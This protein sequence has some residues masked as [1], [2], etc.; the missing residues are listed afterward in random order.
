MLATPGASPRRE[1]GARAPTMNDLIQSLSSETGTAPDMI[2]SVLGAI[3]DFLR[4]HLD[5][6]LVDQIQSHVPG[7]ADLP[8]EP[9]SSEQAQGSGVFGTLSR[10]VGKVFGGSVAGG[11][12]LLSHLAKTG[13]SLETLKQIIPKIVAYLEAHLP[14]ELFDQIKSHLHFPAEEGAG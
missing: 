7:S 1:A 5:P 9:E 3:F 6:G 13:L 4:K 12:D 11:I 2:R 8:R 14:P 10:A